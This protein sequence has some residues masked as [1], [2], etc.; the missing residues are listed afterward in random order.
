M[1][2]PLAQRYE[3][4]VQSAYAGVTHL[5]E[6]EL[7]S[8]PETPL[9]EL[10]WQSRWFAGDFGQH[11]LTTQGEPV[12]I[13]QFGW[14]N[15]GA[16]PDFRECAIRFRGEV[17][18]GSIELDPEARAWEYHGHAENPVYEDVVLHM[19]FRRETTE[20]FTR[21]ASHRMVPQVL[22]SDKI[23]TAPVPTPQPA[24]K[25][26]RCSLRL[27]DWSPGQ[28]TS[29]FEAA[30]RYRLELKTARWNRVIQAHGWDQAVF[31]GLAETLGYANNKLPMTVLAQRL[32]L[33]QLQKRP[34]EREALCF[35]ASGFLDGFNFDQADTITKSYL[36][37]LWEVWWKHRTTTQEAPTRPA[38]KWQISAVRPMNHPQR[39][40]AALSEIAA[41]WAK[42]R[43]HLQPAEAFVEKEFRALV[44]SLHH[45]YWDFH[46]TL[47]SNP[48]TKRM[49]LIG[50]TRIS[51][52]LS[53]LL[54][55]LLIP[56]REPLWRSYCQR[57]APLDNEKT[58]RAALRL[59]GANVALADSFTS[60]LYQHQALLQI[61]QDF[62]CQDASDCLRCPFPEQ[63]LQ[64]G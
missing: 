29:L 32:P 28:I 38:L 19:F 1:F 56:E 3:Q 25:P 7:L 46:Y 2:S 53:N 31:Q 43:R 13:V 11:F 44:E 62:C 37:T 39:R 35:G 41:H 36:R 51:D 58:K 24:A 8:V 34:D 30:A 15:H 12:E 60:K 10:E 50:A 17:L 9:T 64:W 47:T 33:A 40:V 55:P 18:R 27:N 21:T 26:G 42:F 45:P 49:A 14:W 57:S 6:T 20:F 23:A 61:Y 5:A 59:F 16:G 54:F 4:F 52:M 22:L 48:S 63:I